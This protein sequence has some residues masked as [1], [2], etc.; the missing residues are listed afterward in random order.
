MFATLPKAG[1]TVVGEAVLLALEH[2]P[3][4]A[5]PLIRKALL[6][7]IPINRIEVASILALIA[8][9]WS[10]Q[11]LLGA[12]QASDD[13]EMTADAR[14]ALLE[15]GD[16]ESQKAVLAWEERNPHENETGSYLDIGG[17][18]FG[19]FYTFGEIALK[20]KSSRIRY[21]MEKL[22]DRVMKIRNVVPPEPPG[23]RPWW[24]LWGT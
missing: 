18:R 21:E 1:G 22:R 16:E 2:A 8:K 17:R 3:E 7:D 23:P 19:P 5:L 13:Q 10:R 24:K 20:N 6:A 11:E 9:P 15:S 4:L 14:A 12:L